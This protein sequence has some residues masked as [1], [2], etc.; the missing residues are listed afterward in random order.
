ML[1][2]SEKSIL[3]HVSPA[4]F[5]KKIVQLLIGRFDVVQPPLRVRRS[6]VR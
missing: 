4:D 3:F 5:F 1:Y 2:T 6:E